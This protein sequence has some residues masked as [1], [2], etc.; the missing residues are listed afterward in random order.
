MAGGM[1]ISLA[2][3]KLPLGIAYFL[4]ASAALTLTRYDGGVAFLWVAC[5]LLIADLL[6]TRRS[7][8]LYSIVPCVL[9]SGLAT[10][11]FGLG[12]NVAPLFCLLNAAEAVIAA[13][14]IRRS[15]RSYNMLGSLAS[16][17]RFH[18]CRGHYRALD[19]CGHG[20]IDPVV[21]GTTGD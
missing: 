1:N 3:S 5:A 7:R 11:L 4:A 8:W 12:W 16:L 14:L 15:G 18:S 13:W 2:V 19:R 9:A 21:D 10:G 6:R 17:R 20:G